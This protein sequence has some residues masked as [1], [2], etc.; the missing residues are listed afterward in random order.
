MTQITEI[1]PDMYRICTFVPE[2]N[3]QFNQFLVRDDEPLLFHTGMKGLFPV[4]RRR[5][6]VTGS[7]HDP[8]D[9]LQPFRGR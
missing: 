2:V 5:G 8:V 7:R 1:A 4:V 9:Q 3:L 6:Y